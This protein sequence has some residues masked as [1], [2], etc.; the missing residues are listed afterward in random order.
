MEIQPQLLML[1]KSMMLVEGV[2][3]LLRPDLNTWRLI[4]PMIASWARKNLSARAQ[5]RDGA[6]D[7]ADGLRKLPSMLSDAEQALQ[8]LR[9]GGLKLHP[10][11][12][13]ALQRRPTQRAP[14]L[15]W[16]GWLVAGGLL[17][18]Y[19]IGKV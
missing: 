7:L 18:L 9:A 17:V 3:I 5:L 15:A 14:L 2:G 6:R 16:A 4:D 8:S 11:S 19:F 12:L 10:E 13:A 1:Q